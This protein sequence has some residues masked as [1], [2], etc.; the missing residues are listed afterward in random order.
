[1]TFLLSETIKTMGELGALAIFLALFAVV[2]AL[3]CGA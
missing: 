3:I 2:C 1:M